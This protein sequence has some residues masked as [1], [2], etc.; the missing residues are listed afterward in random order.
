MTQFQNKSLAYTYFNFYICSE[1]ILADLLVSP[2][3][4][5]PEISTSIFSVKLLIVWFSKMSENSYLY[6]PQSLRAQADVLKCIVLPN[7]PNPK[8]ILLYNIIE[9]ITKITYTPDRLEPANFGHFCLK[10]GF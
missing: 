4:F 8:Y 7:S 10:N 6:S 3:C 1:L 5:I 9:Y 2:R